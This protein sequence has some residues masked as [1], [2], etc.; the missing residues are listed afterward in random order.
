MALCINRVIDCPGEST[1]MPRL[2]GDTAN[3][4]VDHIVG[5]KHGNTSTFSVLIS[6]V[7]RLTNVVPL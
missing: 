2:H 7:L 3:C 1:D 6:G 5:I 4:N